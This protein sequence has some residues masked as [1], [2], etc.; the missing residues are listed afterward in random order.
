MPRDPAAASQTTLYRLRKQ[1]STEL[2]FYIQRKYLDQGFE[3]NHVVV[4]GV[5]ALLV[6]GTIATEQADWVSHA[7]DLTGVFP[8]VG[9][10]TAAGVLLVPH[11]EYIYALSWGMGFLTLNAQSIDGGFGL[12]FAIRRANPRRVRS[13][14]TSAIDA[15]PLVA[16]TSVL[17]GA[18][19]RA[20]RIEEVG[21]VL[22]RLVV[23]VPAEGLSCEKPGKRSWVTIRGADALSMPLGKAPRSLL[24]DI[25]TLH[26]VVEHE[27]VVPGLEHLEGTRPLRADNLVVAVLNERLAMQLVEVDSGRLALSWPSEW[28]DERGEAVRYSCTGFG[29]GNNGV[30]DDLELEDLTA[31]LTDI[32]VDQRLKA[33]KRG[34]IQG[35]DNDGDAVSRAITANKWITFE[36]D[37]EGQRYV[38]SRGQ[39]YNVGGAYISMLRDKVDKILS[40]VWDETLPDW[41]KQWKTRKRAPH[42]TYLGPVSETDYNAIAVERDGR[43]ICLDRKLL[44]T[45]QHP[46]GIESCDL[47][48]P[49][50]ELVHV[51]RLGDSVSASHL[52]NQAQ[53]SVEALYRQTDA[54]ERFQERVREQSGG[55]RE[56][57]IGFRPHKVVLAF[58]GRQATLDALFTFSQVTLQRCAQ[59]LGDFDVELLVTEIPESDEIV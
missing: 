47:L 35:L 57:P 18:A 26:N 37:Y 13:V 40:H 17:G 6:Y 50:N 30:V 49:G 55:T 54:L 39:W 29:R 46:G 42:E 38:Y 14:T 11:E 1:A 43:L 41:P 51:K 21:E 12:R 45:D 58:G 36:D 44:F 9:N 5:D 3:S 31:P 20:F 8:A 2:D 22:S 19:L 15:L 56:I 25:A 53:V 7:G 10:K 48:G 59:R 16:K 4:D 34:K 52:F 32:P 27:E 28:Q 23:S 33:L 24:A